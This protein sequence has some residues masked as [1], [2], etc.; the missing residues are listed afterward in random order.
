MPGK[1]SDDISF[2]SIV[3]RPVV[4]GVITMTEVKT[5]LVTLVDLLKINALLDMKADIEY[6]Y[7]KHPQKKEGDIF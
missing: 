1:L 3:W 5:G 7:A 4:A 2:E 6:Y